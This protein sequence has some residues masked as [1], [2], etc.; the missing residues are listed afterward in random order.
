MFG[1]SQVSVSVK[2]KDDSH[3]VGKRG[4]DE[5]RGKG[6]FEKQVDCTSISVVGKV[7]AAFEQRCTSISG[8]VVLY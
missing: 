5:E 3:F 1:I 8:T 6:I 4:Q 2:L 7:S